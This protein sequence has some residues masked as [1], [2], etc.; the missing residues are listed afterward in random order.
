MKN[1]QKTTKI[2]LKL[3]KAL[4]IDLLHYAQRINDIN[5]LIDVLE[6]K[7]G[8]FENAMKLCFLS[9]NYEKMIDLL[10]KT[11]SHEKYQTIV[12]I[13]FVF[14]ENN[15]YEVLEEIYKFNQKSFIE[16]LQFAKQFIQQTFKMRD[17]KSIFLKYI[18][19]ESIH[20]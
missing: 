9:K 1:P 7:I 4:P 11:E 17:T 10:F 14:S 2:V 5:L 6:N 20:I 15:D 13:K 19:Q 8:S 16:V 3:N 12:A 18:I